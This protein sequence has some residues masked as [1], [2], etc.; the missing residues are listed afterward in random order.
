MLRNLIASTSTLVTNELSPSS[1]DNRD[2]AVAAKLFTY[3]LG[4]DGADEKTLFGNV[5]NHAAANAP[6]IGWVK[7]E[8]QDVSYLSGSGQSHFLVT[9][10]DHKNGS[11]WASFAAPASL[12]QPAPAGIK[13]ANGTIYVAFGMS[14]GDNVSFM[15]N[16]IQSKFT[17]DQYLGA[18]PVGWTTNPSSFNFSP[19]LYSYF[20]KF[21]PQSNEMEAGP[22][23]VGYELSETGTNMTTFATQSNQ[24]MTAL[25]MS[26]VNN[27][28]Y[29]LT[30]LTSFATTLN[31]PFVVS[32]VVSPTPTYTQLTST[33]GTVI[34]GQELFYN[35]T[36][37]LNISAVQNYVN[38][39]WVSTAPL[40]INALADNATLAPTDMLYIA[41]QL[42]LDP[43]KKGEYV[44]LTPAEMG[45]TEANYYNSGS[46]SA[47]SNVQAVSG[48]TLLASY[49]VNHM[50]NG[51][52]LMR[53]RMGAGWTLATTGNHEALVTSQMQY[54]G[55]VANLLSTSAT[56]AN[57]VIAQTTLTPT[58]ATGWNHLS[59]NVAGTGTAKIGVYNGTAWTYS[60]TVT[61][62]AA[63]QTLQL[64]STVPASGGLFQ[65]ILPAQTGAAKVYFI[66]NS[67]AVVSWAMNGTSPIV[68]E[69]LDAPTNVTYNYTPSLIFNIPA[70]VGSDQWAYN[71]VNAKPSTQYVYSVDVAGS[72]TVWMNAYGGQTTH[73]TGTITLGPQY[74][75]LS[76]TITTDANVGIAQMQVR[77]STQAS[78]VTMY[79]RNASVTPVV[80]TNFSTGVETGQTQLAWTNTVDTTSPGGNENN[81]ASAVLQL[82]TT[83]MSHGGGHAMQYGGTA[84][85]GTANYA[86]MEAFSN[87]TALTSTSRLSYWIFPQSPLGAEPNSSST[88]VLNSTCVAIDI[89]FTNS[90]SLRGKTA[91]TD[92]Y[93][94]QMHPAH[95]CNHLH[96]DQWN[97]VTSDFSSLSGLTVSRIDI[98]YDQPGSGA[99]G[100]YRGYVDDISLT[101]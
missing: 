10:N 72:G 18:V 49:P 91:I 67:F 3:Y 16:Q 53:A 73:N 17:L 25:G 46:L 60:S 9:T 78:P 100:S 86:L 2:Y 76:N 64:E 11:V 87:S 74:Q 69:V 96:P 94:N 19:N 37:A 59:V 81:V 8:R 44:F 79:I 15:Q 14:D 48:T 93:G 55:F 63:Y 62:T 97:Y 38:A 75:T 26:S 68:P 98:G 33:A 36:P 45:L 52:G 92:Q 22:S 31:L 42:E 13:A 99:A 54:L 21:L 4:S 82:T 35:A 61:L 47:T 90:T 20:Y 28:Q 27:W 89:I 7:D 12:S 84:S 23:G 101:H 34:D 65:V 95:M 39:H 41:D 50:Q 88:T 80:P 85:G 5:L 32:T 6:V 24:F 58:I 56:T 51:S 40:F 1:P 66:N 43:N 57:S 83:E 70:N 71:I 29:N 30:D 77:A